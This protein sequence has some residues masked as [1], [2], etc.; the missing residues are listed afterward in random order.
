MATAGENGFQKRREDQAAGQ[1]GRRVPRDCG[2]QEPR[3]SLFWEGE[4][5]A[6]EEAMS[7]RTE[8]F[9]ARKNLVL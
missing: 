3:A 9:M 8:N 2:S 5:S 1:R 6:T 4:F 7:L